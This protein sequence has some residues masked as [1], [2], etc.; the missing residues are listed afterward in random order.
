MLVS[1]NTRGKLVV[2]LGPTASGKSALAVSLAKKWNGEV[3]SADSR[4]VY[5]GMD[6]GSGKVPRDKKGKIKDKKPPL[7]NSIEL[8]SSRSQRGRLVSHPYY[9]KGVRHHLLDVA[10][11]KRM[12][13]AEEYKRRTR[14][15]IA[16][17]WKRGKLPILCGGTGFYIDAAVYGAEFP[18]VPPSPRLRKE[19]RGKSTEALFAELA[20]VDPERAN[21]IDRKNRHRV[22]R[23]LEIARALGKVPEIK[24]NPLLAEILF[25]GVKKDSAELKKLISARLK[26][27]MKQ[28]MLAEIE[29]LHAPP[30]GG[31]VSW[32]RLESFGL[33]YKWGALFLEGKISKP[34]MEEG[35]LKDSVR[36]AKRQMTWFKRNKE[37]HWVKTEREFFI[38]A[39]KFIK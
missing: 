33:E 38:L 14:K 25:I 3:V 5:R 32:K 18:N 11:P 37:I 23:S 34:E 36:Y 28:G 12:F 26:K 8:L 7:N 16:E 21:S 24:R 20:R 6:L 4:Q 29:R 27:R 22:M 15:A 2:V 17:I 1:K 19:M 39:K 35:I 30:V 10:S 9:H 31:G 13:T